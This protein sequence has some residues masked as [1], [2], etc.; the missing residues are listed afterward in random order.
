M[1]SVYILKVIEI[2]PLLF[3]LEASTFECSRLFFFDFGS[4]DSSFRIDIRW[5]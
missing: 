1:K 2:D 4:I 5:L 3:D